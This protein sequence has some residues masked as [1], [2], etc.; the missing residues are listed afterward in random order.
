MTTVSF[1]T[2]EVAELHA[3]NCRAALAATGPNCFVTSKRG[4]RPCTAE[5]LEDDEAISFASST[6]AG[7]LA[8]EQTKRQ[9]GAAAWRAYWGQANQTRVV[10]GPL[11]GRGVRRQLARGAEQIKLP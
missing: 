2:A 10:E 6:K 7:R 1:S 8:N 4:A 11:L 5:E 9:V 3:A